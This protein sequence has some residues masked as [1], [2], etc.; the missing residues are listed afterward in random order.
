VETSLPLLLTRHSQGDCSL[1]EIAKWMSEAPAR[2]YKMKNKGRIQVG[3]DADLTLV[4]AQ[5]KRT[6]ENGKLFTKVNWSPYAGMEL[7][8]WPVRTI[9]HGQTVF[10]DGQVQPGIRGKEIQFM[11][12]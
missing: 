3:Y 1:V 6:V 5:L 4:D 2:L 11:E 10:V 9:V 7:T 8:G 12:D